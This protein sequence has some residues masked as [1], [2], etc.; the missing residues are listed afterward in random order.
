MGKNLKRYLTKE[1]T[2]M[3]NKHMKDAQHDFP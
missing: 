3:E 1:D 2:Q